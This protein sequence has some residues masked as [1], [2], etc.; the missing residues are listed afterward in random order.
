MMRMIRSLSVLN[1]DRHI[2][3]FVYH[4]S[5]RCVQCAFGVGMMAT[6]TIK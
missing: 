4:L 2:C 1:S 6:S 5:R 3:G